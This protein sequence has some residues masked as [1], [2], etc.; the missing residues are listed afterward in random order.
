MPSEYQ[1]SVAS[2]SE[3]ALPC[4]YAFC[5]ANMSILR[6]RITAGQR[7]PGLRCGGYLSAL[8]MMYAAGQQRATDVEHFSALGDSFLAQLCCLLECPHVHMS[9]GGVGPESLEHGR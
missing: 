8:G 2:R 7:N 6:A 9:P 3:T 1:E 4:G 5:C